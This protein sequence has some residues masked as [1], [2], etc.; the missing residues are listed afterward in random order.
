MSGLVWLTSGTLGR[1]SDGER[2]RHAE[3]DKEIEVVVPARGLASLDYIDLVLLL[4]SAGFKRAVVHDAQCEIRSGGCLMPWCQVA[5]HC[6]E[7]AQYGGHY[8]HD[9][10]WVSSD[11]V[12]PSG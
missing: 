8:A 10:R 1:V 3:Y 11:E 5:C 9:A 12:A 7:R 4:E 6:G 2:W